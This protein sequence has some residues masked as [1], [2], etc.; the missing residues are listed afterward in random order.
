MIVS[1]TS[2]TEDAMHALVNIT[3]LAGGAYAI[4]GTTSL[5][6]AGQVLIGAVVACYIGHAIVGSFFML[7]RE[8]RRNRPSPGDTAQTSFPVP[9][10]LKGTN[11]VKHPVLIALEKAGGE[12]RSNKELADLLRCS[13]GQASKSH[14]EVSH[15]LRYH[16]DGKA[17]RI[18]LAS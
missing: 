9:D 15:L 17:V 11:I 12:V 7:K 3:S 14:Q 4:L 13:P 18:S 1:T 10:D 8:A 2:R 5:V 6:A 16:R